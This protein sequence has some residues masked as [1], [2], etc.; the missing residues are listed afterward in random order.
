MS[1]KKWFIYVGDHHEGPFTVDEIWAG[2]DASKF[3]KTGFVWADGMKDWVALATLPEF[4]RSAPPP[5]AIPQIPTLPVAPEAPA[6]SNWQVESPTG[7]TE[8][9]VESNTATNTRTN[10]SAIV[11]EEAS[12]ATAPIA[13]AEPVLE[14]RA[15]MPET[16]EPIREPT[17][18]G[19]T[20]RPGPG[21]VG[22]PIHAGAPEPQTNTGITRTSIIE[23]NSLETQS[24][25]AILRPAVLGAASATRPSTQ[26]PGE[27]APIITARMKPFLYA[28][29][30]V[31]FLLGLQK[32]GITRPLEDKIAAMLSTLPE[33]SDVS[34]EDYQELKKAAKAPISAG[35]QVAVALSKA[36][37]LSP[38]FYVATNLPDGARFEIYVEGVPHRLLNTLSYSGKLDVVS[39]KRLA[40]STPLRYPDGKPI[41]RGEYIVYVM[42]A[43]VG[44][45]D[46]V[47][48]EL[49]PLAP[50]ARNL[51]DRLP[52]N[53]RLVFSKKIFFGAKDATYEQRLKEF[54]DSLVARA[55]NEA[56]EMA[57]ASATL[58][59]QA[60]MS[61]ATYERLKKQPIGPKQKQTWNA[62][63]QN[64]RAIETQ[65][66][67]KYAGKT[68]EQIKDE[69]FHSNLVSEFL[70]VEKILSDLHSVHEK[71]FTTSTTA[72][73]L[74][75]EVSD[76]QKQY[77]TRKAAWKAAVD[78]ALAS[79][80]NPETGLPVA[81]TI[82]GEASKTPAPANGGGNGHG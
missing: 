68:P 21:E 14:S 3:A 63:V 34:P 61:T 39:Q 33:L 76:L 29:V 4:E 44:Q 10:T 67:Q 53:R 31:F 23:V 48:K 80:S 52:Q 27:K 65:L 41:P 59:S 35:P 18:T 79:P 36:D 17:L 60:L 43:P 9:S 62:A 16:A 24:Q 77:D 81:V 64:W 57:Q 6:T 40:K 28:V 73:S 55:K 30:V 2:I 46:L 82:E 58:D 42:E 5:P 74:E 25:P 45:P 12:P 70:A 50:I 1:E 56:M 72:A 26:G 7:T 71:L 15:P 51:P 13:S 11:V 22:G 66:V 38:I 37:P 78:R 75:G 49:L 8:V 47:Y 32:T 20:N 54:H 69:F 19:T